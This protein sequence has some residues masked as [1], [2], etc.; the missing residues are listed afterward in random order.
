MQKGT[1]H[2]SDKRGCV[3]RRFKSLPAANKHRP[4]KNSVVEPRH[5]QLDHLEREYLQLIFVV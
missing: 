4:K 5:T 1:T 2:K 3:L